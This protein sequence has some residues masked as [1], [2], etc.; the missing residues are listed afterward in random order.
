VIENP[1]QGGLL[2]NLPDGGWVAELSGPVK[3]GV[4]R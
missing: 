1:M 4:G 2:V 3:A